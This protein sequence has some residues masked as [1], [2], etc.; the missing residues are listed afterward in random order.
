MAQLVQVSSFEEVHVMCV[1]R[2]RRENIMECHIEKNSNTNAAE[3]REKANKYDNISAN[4][5]NDIL[6]KQRRS[7]LHF[8]YITRTNSL[9]CWF[10]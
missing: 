9:L 5:Q 3:E 7:V 6:A 8:D 10:T 4:G 1:L 2:K